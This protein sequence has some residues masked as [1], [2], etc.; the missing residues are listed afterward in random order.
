MSPWWENLRE[1]RRYPSAVLGLAIIAVLVL[2]SVYTVIAIPYPRAL[3]L[4]RGGEPWAMHPVNARPVWLDR[5]A[6]GDLPRTVIV[7]SRDAEAEVEPFEGGRQVRIAL[8]FDYPYRGF[9]G[10]VNLFL[11]ARYEARE[12]FVRLTWRMPDGREVPLGGRG[13][14]REDRISLSQDWA[15][16][17]RLGHGPV[18]QRAAGQPDRR[19][20]R[21]PGPDLHRQQGNRM[22][23]SE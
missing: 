11:S 3:E 22:G 17:R 9:P 2:L 8:D 18:G 10:E 6:G 14:A 16:E 7:R 15:L 4:W 23:L 12:P 5:L 1:L 13:V 19:A 20:Q 21:L